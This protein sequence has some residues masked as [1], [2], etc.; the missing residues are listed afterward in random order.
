MAN[1]PAPGT[2]TDT[3]A[4]AAVPGWGVF[5]EAVRTLP[6]RML[7]KLPEDRRADPLL[8]QEVARLAIEA[9]ASQTLGWL[10]GDGDHPQ[11][12]PA[13]GQV[14]NVGQPNA[15]TVYRSAAITPAGTYRLR[16]RAGS[17]RMAVISE[18]GPRAEGSATIG[19]HRAVHD[20]NALSFD[21]DGRFDVLLSVERPAE[22]AGDWW[23]LSPTTNMLMMRLVSCDW[24]NEREPTIAIERLDVPPQRPRASADAMEARLRAMHY[25]IEFMALMFVDHHQQLRDE[26]FINRFK[27]FDLSQAGGLAGQFY[28]EGAYELA[29]DEALIVEAKAP[30][31]CRYRSLIL[32]NE[33]YETTDWVNNHASLNDVQAPLDADGVLR[34]VVSARDPGVPNWLDTAGCA[35]GVIQGRWTDCD[36]QPIPTVT[37][38]AAGAVRDHLPPETG[39]VT[40]EQR[41][42]LIR[43]RRSALLQRSLW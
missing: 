8:Q 40:P 25:P 12:M 22:H 13:I 20:L 1:A 34:I 41:E 31:I 43:E 42:T 5:A 29:D 16:G 14:L 21:A 9:I 11:F 15:D 37:K 17:L 28:Y 3:A 6:A 36:S 38:I 26:G 27:V 35:R 33:I 7:A 2:A 32:T 10:G 39:T 24:S 19:A 23:Q 4:S 30:D 18:V